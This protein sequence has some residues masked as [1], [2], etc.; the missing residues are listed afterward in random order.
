M[1]QTQLQSSIPPGSCAVQQ[2][3]YIDAGVHSHR[4]IDTPD[5][6]LDWPETARF[7][8]DQP[9]LF[10][11][12]IVS[13]AINSH[14]SWSFTSLSPL[15]TPGSQ[16]TTYSLQDVE[17]AAVATSWPPSRTWKESRPLMHTPNIAVYAESVP[18]SRMS[19]AKHRSVLHKIPVPHHLSGFPPGLARGK[20][21]PFQDAYL[22]MQT[23]ITRKIGSCIKCRMQRTRVSKAS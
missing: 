17:N 6:M 13:F 5:A 8:S 19:V 15:I 22:R 20:R 3:K 14:S 21:Q 9:P 23:A 18:T 16:S 10:P 4:A 12:A 1:L 2:Q 11:T 7:P